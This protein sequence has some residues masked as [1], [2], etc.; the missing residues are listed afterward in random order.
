MKKKTLLLC[1]FLIVAVSYPQKEL[2]GYRT[3][4][5]YVTQNEPGINDGKIIQIP[6]ES[7]ATVPEILHTFDVTGMQG[8]FPRGR[9]FQAS[10]GKL[11]GVTGYDGA[12]VAQGIPP[13]VLFEYDLVWNRYRVLYANLNSATYGVIEP[14]PG[15]LYGITNAGS[16]IFKYNIETEEFAIAATIPPFQYNNSNYY[17][18]L[19]GELMKASD[20]NLYAV[21]QMAPSVQNIPYPGGI[22]KL[23][24]A[25]GQISKVYVFGTG[26]SDVMYPMYETKLVEGLPGKLYGTA[27][28]G[29]HV[30]PEGVAPS[31][32]GTIFEFNIADNTLAKKYDFD[33]NVNGIYP[34]PLIKGDDGKLYGTLSGINN[35]NY[36]NHDGLLFEYN[37]STAIIRALHVFSFYDDDQVKFPAG[38]LTK[39]SNG[40]FYGRSMLGT[41]EFNPETQLVKQKISSENAYDAQDLIEI[42]RKP[43]YRFLDNSTLAVCKNSAFDFDIQNTNATSYVWKKGST[44]LPSQTTAVLHIPSLSLGDS[45]IYTCTMTNACGTTVTMPLQLTVQNCLGLEQFDLKNAIRLSPNPASNILNI[46]LPETQLLEITQLSISNMLGQTVY[47]I[48]EKN[49]A[50]DISFLKTGIYQLLLRTDLGDWNGRFVKE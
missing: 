20:G 21:T 30:G 26:G 22:Y 42:C 41:Y 10:N 36:P 39:A 1:C 45:G 12:A 50:I 17:P 11:Y 32:S 46:K 40:N 25:N 48:A 8:K 13:G 16:S 47:S 4:Y 49:T 7:D 23:N 9:I 3:V 19:C 27:L 6:L 24:V 2:L 29:Q 31:G 43:S 37:L 18:R 35:S 33:Y 34:S 38:I 14:V 5:N 15:V 28:G 44:T